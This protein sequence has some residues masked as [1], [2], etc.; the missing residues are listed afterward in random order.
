MKPIRDILVDQKGAYFLMSAV[1]LF[2]MVAFAALGVEIG[3]WYSIQGEMGKAIDGAAFAAAKNV[4]NPMFPNSGAIES[5]AVEVAAANFPAGLLDT[6]T[7]AFV[8]NVDVEGKVTVT[9]S[10][11]SVNHLTTV[12]DTGSSHTALGADGSAKL[13]KAEVALVLDISGSMGRPPGSPPIDDLIAGAQN[14]VSNFTAFERDHKFALI[15]FAAGVERDF[16]FDHN[17]VTPINTA[18]AGLTPNNGGTNVEDALA[19]ALTSLTWSA[20]QMHLPKNERTRQVVV[21]FSDGEPTAFR[22]NFTYN[23]T[24]H[25]GVGQVFVNGGK[26]GPDL[27]RHDIQNVDYSSPAIDRMRNTGDGKTSGTSACSGGL[28]VKWHIFSDPTFGFSQAVPPVSAGVEQCNIDGGNGDA[29]LDDYVRWVAQAKALKHAQ[30]LKDAGIEIYTIGLDVT[31][32][33]ADQAFMEALATDADHAHFA[34]NTGQ[35]QGIFQDIANRLKLV[36][37]S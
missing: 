29:P 13:R 35:L 27:K 2:S 20:P 26:V 32:G 23:G 33:G 4:S 12:F 34:T 21:F 8:G 18:I 1:I 15:H 7:P 37:I 24:V 17:Y 30:D 16:Q 14:F 19:Q 3:R 11:N 10:V 25:D 22:G 31:A 9:G 36:L 28:T 5:F 6:D